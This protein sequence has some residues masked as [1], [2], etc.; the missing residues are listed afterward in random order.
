MMPNRTLAFPNPGP[1]KRPVKPL[2]LFAIAILCQL[3]AMGAVSLDAKDETSVLQA[4]DPAL[5]DLGKN[6]A[7][8]PTGKADEAF[9]AGE[10]E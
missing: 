5:R 6:A 2:N 1:K 10:F 7:K 8:A 3:P 4:S 9:A